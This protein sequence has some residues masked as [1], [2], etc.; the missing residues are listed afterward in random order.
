[1]GPWELSATAAF[2]T[3]IPVA[4]RLPGDTDVTGLGLFLCDA[5]GDWSLLGGEGVDTTDEAG[6]PA[7]YLRGTLDEA[8]VVGVLRDR[9]PPYLGPF[10]ADGA[11]LAGVLPVLHPRAS[12]QMNGV[13]LPRWPSLELPL[14]DAGAG[15]HRARVVATDDLGNGRESRLQFELRDF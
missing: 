6:A 4:V 3:A 9:D 1:M 13:T 10:S 7:V 11:P 2:R 5:K 15:V 12:R 14:A 8:G